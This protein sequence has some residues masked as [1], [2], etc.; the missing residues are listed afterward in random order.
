[1]KPLRVTEAEKYHELQQAGLSYL[2]IASKYSKTKGYVSGLLRQ[3]HLYAKDDKDR[4]KF[5]VVQLPTPITTTGDFMVIGDVHVPCTDYD[6]AK[7]VMLVA[8]KHA[9]KKLV[10][11][12]DLFNMDAFSNY[13]VIVKQPSWADERDAARVL[14]KDWTSFFD[15][16]YIIMGNHDRRMQ[17]W[18]QG[19]FEANDIIGMVSTSDKLRVS[20]Y[21]HLTVKSPSGDWLITH[22]KNYSVN[23]LTVASEI[24]NKY[25]CNVIS[26]HEH[27]AAIGWDKY[28]RY[29]IVNNGGLFAQSKLAYTQLDTNKMPNM[30]NAFTMLKNG[31]AKLYSKYPFTDWDNEL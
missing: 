25:Q 9:V 10:V 16:V 21:G 29:V 2:Q 4:K 1:M 24:A 3:Y 5:D 17:K 18:T 7:L 8:E 26:H 27:H 15:E 31:V 23:Q 20:N 19:A 12:G 30:M 11:A 14:F 22:S 6:F 28:K 13:D